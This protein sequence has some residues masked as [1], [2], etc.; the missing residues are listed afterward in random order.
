MN[1]KLMALMAVFLMTTLAACGGGSSTGGT[2]SPTQPAA[3]ADKKDAG[4]PK[5][6]A[7]W[8]KV[9][10]AAKKEK[11]VTFYHNLRP[12]GIQDLIADFNKEYPEIKV[13]EIRLGSSK[14]I[15][16]FTTEAAVGKAPTD[17][18]VTF[19]DEQVEKWIADGWL[20][21]WTPPE[22]KTYA[23]EV[24]FKD[25]L[26]HFQ[27][28]RE[29]I[30]YNKTKVKPEDAPKEWKD[31]FDPKW[32]GKF[33]MNQPWR[34]VP[35]QQVV[36]HWEKNLGITD[37]A[38]AMKAQDVKFFNGSSGVLKAIVTGQVHVAE[39]T[40]LPVEPSIEDGQPIGVVY[41]KSGTPVTKGYAM[42]PAKAPNP[43]AGK[44]FINWLMSEKGQISVQKAGGLPGT[45]PGIPAPK[46]VPATKDLK[47]IDG[48]QLLTPEVQTELLDRWKKTFNVK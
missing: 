15:Q 27:T 2:S 48:S 41:P 21:K 45:R 5:V 36:A 29:A 14:L 1:R 10:E 35:I 9:V 34:S 24:L 13:E 3:G 23:K 8:Q 20:T 7:E 26:F 25:H 6:D 39:I 46:H 28:A 43:N 40:D 47:V 18:L 12:A 44:V 38:A 42:L 32:K 22:I 11:L 30:I 37:A 33:G 17:A 19:Y 16:R 31:L 4:A